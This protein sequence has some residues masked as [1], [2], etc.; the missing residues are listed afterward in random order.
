MLSSSSAS[1]EVSTVKSKFS[2]VSRF[3]V[4]ND[5]KTDSDGDGM[6]DLLEWSDDEEKKKEKK[7]KKEKKRLKRFARQDRV[8]KM[9]ENGELMPRWDG[10]KGFWRF[11]GNKLQVN[12]TVEN[13]CHLP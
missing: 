1:V 4:F 12:G 3:D 2:S 6:A 10:S 9:I 11:F 5:E 13:V 8:E 7:E